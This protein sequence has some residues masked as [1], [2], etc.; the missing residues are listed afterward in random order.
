MNNDYSATRNTA[1][2]SIVGENIYTEWGHNSTDPQ[3][4]GIKYEQQ[5]YAEQA[6]YH[7]LQTV[8][9]RRHSVTHSPASTGLDIP[10]FSIPTFTIKRL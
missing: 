10:P 4:R 9:T 3:L 6:Q 2:V 5:L 8:D 1:D 7:G